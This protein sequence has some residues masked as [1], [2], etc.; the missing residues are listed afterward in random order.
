MPERPEIEKIAKIIS[1]L[2]IETLMIFW[3]PKKTK[4]VQKKDIDLHSGKG[5]DG[6]AGPGG[7]VRRGNPSGTGGRPNGI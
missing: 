1:F 4:K 2:T 5:F 7:E 3:A 6:L